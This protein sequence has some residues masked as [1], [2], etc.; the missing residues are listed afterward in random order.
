MTG[1]SEDHV[2]LAGIETLKGLGW[3]YLDGIAISPDGSAPQRT[4]FGDTIL[5]KR[6]ETAVR[7][8]NPG[9]PDDAIDAAMRQVL[10]TDK[11]NLIEEN[12]RLHRLMTEGVGVQYRADDG[13]IQSDRVWLIDFDNIDANDWMVTNQFTVIEGK[14]NRRPDVVCFLNGMP[15]A[16]LELKNAADENATLTSAFNQLQ[17]YKQQ[18][19]SLFRTNAVLITSDGMLARIGS[20][21]ANEERFMPWRTVDGETYEDAGTPEMDTLLNGVFNRRYFLDLIRNFTVFGDSG[22]GPVQDCCGLSSVPRRAE[23]SAKSRR[24]NGRGRR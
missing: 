18:I 3:L 15:V 1:F 17:T 23:S 10:T 8:L 6:F 4:S 12:R 21:T 20:L 11:P 22:D 9:L 14:H 2:E 19:S 13:T 5:P 24:G 16:V 7:A